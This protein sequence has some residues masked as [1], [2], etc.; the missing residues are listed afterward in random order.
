ARVELKRLLYEFPVTSVYVTHDQVE[1]VA[2][3]HRIAVMRAG[4]IEQMGTYQQLYHNPVN[5]FVATFIG[6]PLMNEFEGYVVDGHWQGR[7]FG[8]FTIRH[9]LEPGTRITMGVRPEN[10][11]LVSEG[12]PA[13]VDQVTSFFAERFK[14]IDVHLDGESWQL[15]APLDEQIEVGSTVQCALNRE[16]VMFFDSK[17]GKRVG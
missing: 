14:L 12:V 8:G 2:L 1:A 4:R 7:N 15:T 10:V 6:T 5:L 3:A 16:N 11:Q 9:D 17:T 13:V